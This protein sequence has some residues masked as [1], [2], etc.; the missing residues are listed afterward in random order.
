M[1]PTRNAMIYN[2]W[3]DSTEDEVEQV[4]V[5]PAPTKYNQSSWLKQRWYLFLYWLGTRLANL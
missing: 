1:K 4:I 5:E 3:F 2:D